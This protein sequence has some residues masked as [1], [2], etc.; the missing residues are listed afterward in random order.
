MSGAGVRGGLGE[1]QLQEREEAEKSGDG[2]AAPALLQGWS[3]MNRRSSPR[4]SRAMS[5]ELRCPPPLFR[6]STKLSIL[7]DNSEPF[8]AAPGISTTVP[9]LAKTSTDKPQRFSSGVREVNFRS[10]APGR[11]G[12]S[13]PHIISCEE[14]GF[15]LSGATFLALALLQ[16]KVRPSRAEGRDPI[17]FTAA[18]LVFT[19]LLDSGLSFPF[20]LLE[21]DTVLSQEMS[22]PAEMSSAAPG[23]V[24]AKQLE[25]TSTK[26]SPTIPDLI[27]RLRWSSSVV[28]PS[29]ASISLERETP[30]PSCLSRIHL[31]ASQ[32]G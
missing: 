15:G 18:P 25:K 2:S 22:P 30:H 6:V 31:E 12:L 1:S 9:Q 13:F 20:V 5:S 11:K 8:V 3:V 10:I 29:P 24:V 7:P 19:L 26:A 14:V 27:I 4:V 23:Q 16:E 28:T 17:D 21:P 32:F